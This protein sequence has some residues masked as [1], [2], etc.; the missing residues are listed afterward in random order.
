MNKDV[1]AKKLIS[2]IVNGGIKG[3][4]VEIADRWYRDEDG[5]IDLM[6][7]EIMNEPQKNILKIEDDSS[8]F[9][10]ELASMTSI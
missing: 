5:E 9:R 7:Y 2:Y 6:K 1:D 10:R 3:K 8:S 4:S